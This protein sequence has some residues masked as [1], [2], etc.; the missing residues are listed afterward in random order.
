MS[1][2]TYPRVANRSPPTAQ[3][4]RERYKGE[5]IITQHIHLAILNEQVR[6]KLTIIGAVRLAPQPHDQLVLMSAFPTHDT[7]ETL[8]NYR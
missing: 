3:S 6:S 4:L 2:S 7:L 8:G 5:L 1:Y